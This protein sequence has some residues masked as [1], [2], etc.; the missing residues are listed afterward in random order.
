MDQSSKQEKQL[1]FIQKTMKVSREYILETCR[2]SR[3]SV[4]EIAHCLQNLGK[5]QLNSSFRV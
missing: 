3:V 1:A 5:T 2:I 4:E